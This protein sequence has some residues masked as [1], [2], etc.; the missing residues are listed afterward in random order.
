MEVG[1]KIFCKVI[2]T[3]DGKIGLSMKLVDQTTGRD[4][5]PEN[6]IASRLDGKRKG[7]STD[8][9]TP[10]ELGAVLDTICKRC[11]V[12]GHLASSCYAPSGSDSLGLVYSSS[13][14]AV[15]DEELSSSLGS[16]KKIKCLVGVVK[17]IQEDRKNSKKHSHKKEKKKN[18]V[19]KHSHEERKR[20]H[21][22]HRD[23]EPSCK[24]KRRSS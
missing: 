4:K 21:R 15:S 24:K 9:F 12:R 13:E 17:K 1:E 20:K 18:K 14:A 2:S 23:D 10:I 3:E 19:G 8:S 6:L 7:K 22:K 5:D 11:G 16:I